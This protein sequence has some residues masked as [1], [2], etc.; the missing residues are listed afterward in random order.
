[1]QYGSNFSLVGNDSH[2]SFG[3]LMG[4]GHEIS[5]YVQQC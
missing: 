3:L 2:R 4:Y 1:M 5:Q